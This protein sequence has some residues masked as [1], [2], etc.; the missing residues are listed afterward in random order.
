VSA[1]WVPKM[2]TEEH[3]SKRMAAW[4][5]CLESFAITKMKENHSWKA[6]LQ[7]MKHG[8]TSSTQSQKETLLQKT[9]VPHFTS[10]GKEH[11]HE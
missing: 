10:L 4:L 5:L 7:E 1:R 8:C 2:L 6:S 9:V 3:K 11:Y